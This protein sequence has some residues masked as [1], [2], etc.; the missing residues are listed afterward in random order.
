V[1]VAVQPVTI[2]DVKLELTVD[3]DVVKDDEVINV[4]ELEEDDEL[5]NGVNLEELEEKEEE[6]CLKVCVTTLIDVC[7]AAI[8]AYVR[9]LFTTVGDCPVGGERS[10]AVVT[11]GLVAQ[12]KLVKIGVGHS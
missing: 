3:N 5:I 10:V 11:Y 2:V 7:E 6:V 4:V 1:A 9:I 8:L 12:P